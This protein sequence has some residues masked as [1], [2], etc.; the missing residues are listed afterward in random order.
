MTDEP[1][2]NDRD[3]LAGEFALGLL[4]G[5]ELREARALAAR[6]PAFASEVARWRGR[7]AP[8]IDEIESVA[9]PK[10]AWHRIEAGIESAGASNVIQL[11][12]RVGFW[13]GATAGMAALAASLALVLVM[14]PEPTVPVATPPAPTSAPPMVAMLSDDQKQMKVMASWNPDARQLVL[15]VAGEATPDPAHAH[16]VWIIPAGGKPRSL[17]TMGKPM[18]H[19]QLADALATLLQQGA[20]IAISAE[21]TGGSPTGA[22]TGPMIASGTLSRA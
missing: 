18:V 14:Q 13:Q 12:R 9:P 20:T 4:G 15:A 22:P 19:M 7:S 21:P 5:D 16:E 8:L 1:D 10:G 17:G 2:S 6:D 3:V 11:R